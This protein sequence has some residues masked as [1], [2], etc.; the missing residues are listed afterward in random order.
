MLRISG[1]EHEQRR[2]DLHQPLDNGKSVESGH[3]DVEEDEIRLVGLDRADRFA[4][5][6]AG[7]DDLDVIVG[8]QAQLQALDGKR[9]VVDQ[10][11]TNGHFGSSASSTWK[12]MSMETRKP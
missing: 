12:G 9:L 7:V 11:R 3:L 8:L 1:D 2:L 4:A 5:V 10:N 6:R